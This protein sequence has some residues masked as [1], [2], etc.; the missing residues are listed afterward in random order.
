MRIHATSFVHEGFRAIRVGTRDEVE[1]F[2]D[3]GPSKRARREVSFESEAV[4]EENHRGQD[5]KCCP[6][7]NPKP[8]HHVF[9]SPTHGRSVCVCVC[10]CYDTRS[11]GLNM[12]NHMEGTANTSSFKFKNHS[13]Y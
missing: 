6:K 2:A 3:E 10:V 4:C 13:G 8:I 7:H 9:L 11:F 1:G 12:R 5:N